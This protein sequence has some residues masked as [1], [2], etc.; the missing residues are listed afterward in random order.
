MPHEIGHIFG[1][2]HDDV[3]RWKD[4]GKTVNFKFIEQGQ[5]IHPQYAR[6][7][8]F[9]KGFLSVMSYRIHGFSKYV[10][11][12]SSPDVKFQG[13]PT[14]DINRDCARMINENRFRVCN[15]NQEYG[16]GCLFQ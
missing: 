1:C 16:D 9:K 12:F 5:D 7:K 14:G 6:G 3:Q 10:N 8:L 11:Y 13:A 4:L 15:I 2:N